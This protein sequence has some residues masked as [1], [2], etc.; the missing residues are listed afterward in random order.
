MKGT[1]RK[2][3]RRV[4]KG[5]LEGVCGGGGGGE[6]GTRREGESEGKHQEKVRQ[7]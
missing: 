2:G 1:A 7:M 4:K 3:E 6:M 5:A